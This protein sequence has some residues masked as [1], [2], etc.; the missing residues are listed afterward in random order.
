M[1]ITD[2][3]NHLQNHLFS[4]DLDAVLERAQHAGVTRF[5]CNGTSPDDW[6]DVLKIA[7]THSCVYPCIGLHPWFVGESKDL[8]GV[9]RSIRQLERLLG[10]NRR[11]ENLCR[12]RPET[13]P[14]KH[15]TLCYQT[16]VGEIGLDR[17]LRQRNDAIQEYAFT[18]QL[19]VALERELPVML[20]SVRSASRMWELLQDKCPKLFVLH[21]FA[22]PTD[23]IPAFLELGAFFSFSA[24]LL[25]NKSRKVVEALQAVPMNRIVLESDSPALPPSRH[26]GEDGKRSGRT[27]CSLLRCSDETWRNE[28]SIIPH[29]LHKL[30]LVK[31]ITVEEAECQ[32]RENEESIFA[33]WPKHGE[34]PGTICP[35][36]PNGWL[37]RS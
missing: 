36:N 9:R 3:H 20:H 5:V 15:P 2:F 10:D 11:H 30:S 8:E 31:K 26:F 27:P 23:I 14:A 19:D 17:S 4:D 22:G 33:A 25:R 28:P 6:Q 24:L 1:G 13:V 29:I 16:G 7:E 21:S 37:G 18:R 34:S 35:D 12:K 32:I